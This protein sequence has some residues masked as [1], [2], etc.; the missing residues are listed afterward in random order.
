MTAM[1]SSSAP[2]TTLSPGPDTVGSH[3]IDT[4]FATGV[5]IQMLNGDGMV[6]A[7]KL[8]VAVVIAGSDYRIV[9]PG[10]GIFQECQDGPPQ[11]GCQSVFRPWIDRVQGRMQVLHGQVFVQVLRIERPEIANL[12]TV[13]VL[14]GQFLSR[15]QTRRHATAGRNTVPHAD[16]RRAVAR[17]L[18]CQAI[19]DSVRLPRVEH[20]I[21]NRSRSAK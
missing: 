7:S 2:N 21:H 3:L 16:L 19:V 14:H 20:A 17:D 11:V 8:P 5:F 12:R 15:C 13:G 18:T 9:D 10:R 1:Q 6:H 4:S